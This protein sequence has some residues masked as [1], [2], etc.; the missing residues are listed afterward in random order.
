[1]RFERIRETFMQ[2]PLYQKLIGFGSLFL[3]I[4][5]LL[6][7][8]SDLNNYNSGDQYLGIT[9][10]AY[11]AGIA[12]LILGSLSFWS[13]SYH[14]LERREPRLPVREAI[15]HLAVAIESLFLLVIVNSFYFDSSFG[16][17][18]KYKESRFGMTIAIVSSLVL[19][20]GG[21]LRN[22]HEVSHASS[23]EEGHLEPLIKISE[24]P[25]RDHGSVGRTEKAAEKTQLENDPA[26]TRSFIFGENEERAQQGEPSTSAPAPDAAVRESS[27]VKSTSPEGGYKIR[28]DL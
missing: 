2:L 27:A 13:F 18:I 12:I 1:M 24:T 26:H 28:M 8:Y 11:L 20:A 10:P 17:A 4:S 15:L 22:R 19:L 25:R 7:W 5:T 14:L 6:P 23:M 16:L 3:V 21:Y 9:G